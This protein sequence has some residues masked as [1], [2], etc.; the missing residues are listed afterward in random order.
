MSLLVKICGL[1]TADAV[2][3]AV[4]AGAD[5]LG[6]VFHSASPRNLL[7]AQAAALAAA[8]PAAVTTVAVTLHPPQSLVDE[9]LKVFRPAAWQTDAADF[10]GLALPAGIAHWPVLRAGALA[11]QPMP[12]RV[13]YEG[14]H[15]GAGVVADW[16]D[17]ARLARRTQLILGGGLNPG[18]VAAAIRAVQPFGVDVSSGVEAAPGRKDP[19]RIHDFVTA[20]RRAAATGEAP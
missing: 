6:F 16:T 12:G 14:P 17:A 11:P 2:A 9:I 1:T 18:N 3:A 20:A 5:A 13:L 7:P 15:S 19:A 8:V 4:D 10:A